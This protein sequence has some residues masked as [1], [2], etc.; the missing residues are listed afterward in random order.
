MSPEA[1]GTPG[2]CSLGGSTQ[3]PRHPSPRQASRPGL[4][5]SLNNTTLAHARASHARCPAPVSRLPTA[6]VQSSSHSRRSTVPRPDAAA[7]AYVYPRASGLDGWRRLLRGGLA[8]LLSVRLDRV[9]QGMDASDFFEGQREEFFKVRAG[10]C[11]LGGAK[12][13]GRA[14]RVCRVPCRHE[15]TPTYASARTTCTSAS[16]RTSLVSAPAWTQPPPLRPG[17]AQAHG[18]YLYISVMGTRPQQQVGAGCGLRVV[19]GGPRCPRRVCIVC[20]C[21]RHAAE[22]VLVWRYRGPLQC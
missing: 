11:G 6:I 7:I 8:P 18:P 5:H 9:V 3:A 4:L 21:S 20:T 15:P 22:R 2:T 13:K 14:A 17:P 19:V 12:G 1:P 10:G 16:T